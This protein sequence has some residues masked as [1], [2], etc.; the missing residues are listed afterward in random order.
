M[1]PR[2][3]L[4]ALLVAALFL[5]LA[6]C[7]RQATSSRAEATTPPAGPRQATWPAWARTRA[8]AGAP[9]VIPHEVEPS[10]T[11][12]DCLSC[13]GELADADEDE[14]A[15]ATGHPDLPNCRQCHLPQAA[16][17]KQVSNA[18]AGRRYGWRGQ[19][20]DPWAPPVIPHPVNAIY[21]TCIN[22]HSGPEPRAVPTRHPE[23]QPCRQCHVPSEEW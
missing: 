3:S 14:P 21:D 12:E 22:C 1:S 18:F 7:A 8:Y 5:A 4:I 10:D 15:P 16:P 23:L 9:P 17:H 20:L 11:D 6:G 2:S 13:H 19:Q